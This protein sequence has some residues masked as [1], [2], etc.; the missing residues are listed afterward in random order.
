MLAAHECLQK[1]T[2]LLN[3]LKALKSGSRCSKRECEGGQHSFVDLVQVAPQLEVTLNLRV[4]DADSDPHL[5][6][7][8]L[9]GE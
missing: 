1:S 8:D 6:P 3:A 4:G 5:P 2:E 9:E 7:N